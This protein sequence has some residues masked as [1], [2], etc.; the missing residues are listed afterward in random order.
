MKNYTH[1]SSRESGQLTI[2]VLIFS[3][4]S[5]IVLS[6]FIL[7]ADSSIKAVFRDFDRAQSFMIAESGIE[8]YRWHL[9]HAPTDYQDGTGQPGPYV[10]QFEDRNGNVIG[11][12]SL[13][14]TAPPV[15]STVVRV[16]STGLITAN[17][18]AT[19]VIE[20]QMAIPSFAKYAVVI[21]N[22]AVRFGEGTEL[23]GPIHSN[24]GLRMD[25]ISHNLVT[26]AVASYDDPDH[27][28]ANEFGVHTHVAPAD[29]FPP[30]T[31]PTRPD[32]FMAGRQFPVAP[33][34][35]TGITADLAK[36][37][38]DA[39]AAGAYRGPSGSQGYEIIFN[40]ND[41]YQ[42]RRVNSQVSPPTN[43][44]NS[45]SQTGWGTWSVNSTTNLGTFPLPSNGLIFVEDNVWVRGQINTARVT[46]AS[47]RFPDNV[48]TRSSI[49][50]NADL[51]YTNYDGSDVLSL[52]AQNNINI[53]MVSDTDLRID[54]ALMA[55]NGRVGRYYYQ[56]PTGSRCSPY[57]ARTTITSYGMIASNQRYGFA[58]TDNTGYTNRVIIY[59]ANL[60]YGPPPSFPLTADYYT[61][62]FWNEAQ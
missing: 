5:I 30:A 31:A 35:F 22:N 47:G 46:V 8:Y 24:G 27:S 23:F 51:L 48:S 38:T 3:A 26:S 40:T 50:V 12:F 9:A 58:Y 13:A 62:I 36:M 11:S 1:P 14:I 45:Q 19:K 17:P 10:H 54:A 16:N 60:L 2:Y 49:T 52:V 34:D 37:K 25:G 29:P 61:P 7:W 4:L 53:G 18:G 41:T 59:D 56:G 15:G 21:G 57:H 42:L 43:C 32:V 55:Q 44:T 33:T 28:G 39:Q 6:G 20:S